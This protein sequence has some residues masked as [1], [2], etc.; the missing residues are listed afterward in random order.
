MNN[1]KIFNSSDEVVGKIKELN[2]KGGT[3]SV[4]SFDFST[5]YTK[6]EHE[7]LKAKLKWAIETAFESKQGSVLAVYTQR[8]G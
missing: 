4:G 6:L 5:L 8:S 7:R 3:S 1:K 2:E